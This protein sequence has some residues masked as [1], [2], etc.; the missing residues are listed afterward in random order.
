MKTFVKIIWSGVALACM[1]SASAG[2]V[3]VTEQDGAIVLE[4]VG[5]ADG[6]AQAASAP[7]LA[8]DAALQ[9]PAQSGQSAS[10]SGRVPVKAY[11]DKVDRAN[12]EKRLDDRAAR[13]KKRKASAE[14]ES[15]ERAARTQQMNQP[16]P[17]EQGAPQQE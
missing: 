7:A 1:Q 16:A 3:A 13:T 2:E 14:K 12:I 11:Y 8:S 6:S 9:A 5:G 4:A 17:Q 10:S 15:A